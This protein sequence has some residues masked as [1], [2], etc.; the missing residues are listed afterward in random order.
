MQKTINKCLFH[1]ST[2]IY[3]IIET[4]YKTSQ[5]YYDL[6]Y[7][8][9]ILCF[10]ESVSRPAMENCIRDNNKWVYE[11]LMAITSKNAVKV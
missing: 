8:Y 11:I 9:A 10:L 5:R 1:I 3:T 4:P 7:Q 6:P 2:I